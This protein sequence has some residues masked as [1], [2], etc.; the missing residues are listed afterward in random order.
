MVT[1]VLFIFVTHGSMERPPDDVVTSFVHGMP[2]ETRPVV[3]AATDPPSDEAVAAAAA[4]AGAATAVVVSWEDSSSRVARLRILEGLPQH[5]RWLSR[6]ISFAASDPLLERDRALGLVIATIVDAG[7][8]SGTVVVRPPS[9]AAVASRPAA[10]LPAPEAA[11]RREPVVSVPRPFA[12]ALEA[13]IMTA[14]DADNGFEETVG[15]T[16]AVRRLLPHALAARGGLTL[17][18]TE[19]DGI[20]VR[21]QALMGLFGLAWTARPYRGPRALGL[22]VRA[23]VLGA[24][25]SIHYSGGPAGYANQQAFWSAGADL[26]VEAGFGLSPETALLVGLGAETLFTAADLVVEQT[27]LATLPRNRV[28][29]QLGLVSGF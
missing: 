23:D 14:L 24:R 19:T 3:Q 25:E 20:E 21:T 18:S 28:I 16:V 2:Q 7:L 6:R 29:L 10:A 26:V 9:P 1:I 8:E 17:R 22:G 12:W 4:A 13:D 5:P 15:G 27:H 11:P